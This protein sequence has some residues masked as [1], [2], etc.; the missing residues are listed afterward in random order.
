MTSST[1]SPTSLPHQRRYDIVIGANLNGDGHIALSILGSTIVS[2][3]S[4][5]TIEDTI[6]REKEDEQSDEE[7]TDEE[8]IDDAPGT[9]Q[10]WKL[11]ERQKLWIRTVGDFALD[12]YKASNIYDQYLDDDDDDEDDSAQLETTAIDMGKG[13]ST[14]IKAPAEGRDKTLLVGAG[15]SVSTSRWNDHYRKDLTSRLPT[16]SEGNYV[17]DHLVV[18]HNHTDHISYVD[19]IIKNN[20]IKV[21]N[22]YFNGITNVDSNG[23]TIE[24]QT[25]IDDNLNRNTNSHIAGEGDTFSLGESTVEVFSPN[26][27]V[28]NI[29]RSAN[30]EVHDSYSIVLHVQHSS[31]E[32]LTTGDIR[33]SE[34]DYIANRYSSEL[35]NVDVLMAS[36]HG[37]SSGGYNVTK[38]E[39]LKVTSPRAVIISNSN[40]MRFSPTDRY[41]PDCAIFDRVSSHGSALYWTAI[42]GDIQF[43][44]GSY[45]GADKEATSDAEELQIELPYQCD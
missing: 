21:K 33:G 11:S 2:A 38:E 43:N 41:A 27:S 39:I 14:L 7:L 34:E 37:T 16:N 30:S 6:E 24:V 4:V 18:S 29:E 23:N 19:E 9:E 13:Q 35:G 22:I 42:H 44:G 17:I 8:E 12:V 32:L 5:E 40:E 1:Y 28:D 31:G 26:G 20:N 10:D 25:E 45:R 3:T 15:S 36:H